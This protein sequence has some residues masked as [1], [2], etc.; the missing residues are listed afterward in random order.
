MSAI[1]NKYADKV[2][3]GEMALEDVP[4]LWREKVR[5]ELE[6]R[7]QVELEPVVEEVVT[8]EVTETEV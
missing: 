4:K 2:E 3:A 8:D 6:K 5:L 1:A 7:Q